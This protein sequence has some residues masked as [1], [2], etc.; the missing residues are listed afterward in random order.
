VTLLGACAVIYLSFR[1]YFNPGF[2][3]ERDA[4]TERAAEIL[5]K[6][7]QIVFEQSARV[8]AVVS[9]L[10][11]RDPGQTNVFFVGFAGYGGQ[12]V[13][14]EEIGLAARRF[15]DRYGAAQRSVLLVNDQRDSLKYPLASVPSLRHSLNALSQRMNVDEDILILSLSS[16]GSED[17]TVTVSSELGYWRDLD[18]DDLAGMLRESGIRWRVIVVSA[19]YAGTFVEPLRDDHTIII[20]AAAEDRTSFG[21]SDENDLTY[22]GEAFYRDALPRATSLRAAFNA[23]RVAIGERESLE[24]RK[25]SNPQAH[26]G[27]ALEKKLSALEAA[28]ME[29]RSLP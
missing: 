21:C 25:H 7:E 1:V 13:F 8:N 15:G 23:A 12:K 29:A 14:A 22:F 6:N 16:H 24:G 9:S 3:I 26:F 4:D 27:A 17:G 10:A 5:H 20:T 28:A 11:P 18:A 19:C 2:W